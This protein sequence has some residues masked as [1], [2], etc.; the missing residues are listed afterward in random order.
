MPARLAP[1]TGVYG[2][3]FVF[4]M[5]GTAVALVALRRPRIELAPLAV[6]L[7]LV[8]LPKLPEAQRGTETAVLVQPNASETAAWTPQWVA[9]MRERMQSLSLRAALAPG[10][11][12]PE[13]IV[14]PEAPLPQYYDGDAAFRDAV[15]G[16]ARR[17]GAYLI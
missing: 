10:A 8:L 17:T 16:L 2:I 9:D 11:P 14:W 12:P 6:L 5:M 4:A 3:S 13:F 7:L 1:Y 15:N